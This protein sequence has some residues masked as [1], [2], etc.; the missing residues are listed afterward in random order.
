MAS[1]EQ[2]YPWDLKRL[3]CSAQDDQFSVYTQTAQDRAHGITVRD[4]GDDG[5]GAAQLV[6]LDR[7]ILRFAIDVRRGAKFFRQRLLI[8][9]ACDRDGFETHLRGELNSQV[10]KAADAKDCDKVAGT[11]TAVT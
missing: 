2:R 8:E 4:G 1:H 11:R 6:Q 7:G 3:R 9:P 5:F 10:A